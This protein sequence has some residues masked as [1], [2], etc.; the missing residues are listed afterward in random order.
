MGSVKAV[1]AKGSTHDSTGQPVRGYGTTGNLLHE[2]FAARTLG[3]LQGEA[4]K[5]YYQHFVQTT[6]PKPSTAQIFGTAAMGSFSVL[7]LGFFPIG[8]TA[9]GLPTNRGNTLHSETAR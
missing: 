7:G 3:L 6:Y 8:M 5:L 2:V 1:D 4:I 9:K